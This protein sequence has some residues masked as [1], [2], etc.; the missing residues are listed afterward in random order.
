MNTLIPARVVGEVHW[1]KVKGHASHDDV[2]LGR[3]TAFDI[4]GNDAADELADEYD[5]LAIESSLSVVAP[6]QWQGADA[7]MLVKN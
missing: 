6:L 3:S 1:V 2:V 5:G 4:H 7:A